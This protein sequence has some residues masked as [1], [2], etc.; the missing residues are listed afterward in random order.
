MGVADISVPFSLFP[1]FFSVFI[2]P[3]QKIFTDGTVDIAVLSRL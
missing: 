2:W 3:G 1:D